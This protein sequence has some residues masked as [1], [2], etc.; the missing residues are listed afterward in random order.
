MSKNNGEKAAV[1]T[2]IVGGRPPGNGKDMGSVPLGIEI[3]LKKAAIDELFRMQ[4][5]QDRS[6]AADAIG[7]TLSPVE[8]SILKAIPDSSLEHMVGVTRVQPKLKQA[9][10]GYTAAVMLAAL[11]ATSGGIAQNASQP[12]PADRRNGPVAIGGIMPSIENYKAQSY[13]KI[14]PRDVKTPTGDLEVFIDDYKDQFPFRIGFFK[15]HLVKI[16]SSQQLENNRTEGL[17]FDEQGSFVQQSIPIGEY[18][19]EICFAEGGLQ[20]GDAVFAKGIVRSKNV[21]I[22][23]KKST[24]LHFKLKVVRQAD[25]KYALDIE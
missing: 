13:M 19:I 24:T 21:T 14:S 1:K 11:T 22:E 23:E 9:F 20:S 8:L 6:S 5:L 15:I 7:L 18:R 25:C 17:G 4:F 12:C 10:M 2:T 3:L 16:E